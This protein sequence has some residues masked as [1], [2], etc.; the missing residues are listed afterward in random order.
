MKHIAIFASGSGTNAENIIRY[1]STKKIANVSL[2]LSNK[3][4]ALVLKRAETLG[5]QSL[6]FDHDDFYNTGAVMAKLKSY[7][8]DYIVLAGFLW[9]VPPEIID[10]YR[11]RIIN[12]HPALLP[13]YGGKGMYGDAVH[14]AVI[15]NREKESGITI[16]H[17]N[18]AFDEGDIIFQAKCSIEPGDT[19]ESLAAKIHNLE[20]MHFPRVIEEE[21]I[22]MS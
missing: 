10:E 18:Y 1:F 14:K 7:E 12:I 15:A 11:G 17:V 2:V 4:Q 19:P 3:S 9:L 20:Y 6:F 13:L 22:R 5:I 16:H 8:I 21:L